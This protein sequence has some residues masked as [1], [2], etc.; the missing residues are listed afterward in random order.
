LG[1]SA[2]VLAK[3][4][5]KNNWAMYCIGQT[6]NVSYENILA[7][8]FFLKPKGRTLTLKKGKVTIKNM[9]DGVE[10]QTHFWADR[11]YVL[12]RDWVE[13]LCFWV[14]SCFLIPC[15]KI[16]CYCFSKKKAK[17]AISTSNTL[18]ME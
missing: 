2:Y 3:I 17:Y 15:K 9:D 1:R 7:L 16:L 14:L 5:V 12:T 8:S 10:A 6:T 13:L 18:A 11:Y 4:I